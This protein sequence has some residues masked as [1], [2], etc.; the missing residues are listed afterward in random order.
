M[1]ITAW[2]GKWCPHHPN[3]PCYLLRTSEWKHL[4]ASTPQLSFMWPPGHEFHRMP[5]PGRFGF[6]E[7]S[8]LALWNPES[9][10]P[11]AA[12]KWNIQVTRNPFFFLIDCSMCVCVC[13]CVC[14]YQAHSDII[15]VRRMM[16]KL[17]KW[18]RS[19]VG[20]GEVP[21][22]TLWST[23]LNSPSFMKHVS[24]FL[25]WDV[26]K[27]YLSEPSYSLPSIITL[28]K[29]SERIYFNVLLLKLVGVFHGK[30][31]TLWTLIQPQQSSI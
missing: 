13:V 5:G 30:V 15:L 27:V 10:T 16:E 8:D 20:D 6:V 24:C 26:S 21:R 1:Q 17:H 31:E 19:P 3:L 9:L 28:S 14:V 12:S 2:E 7:F 11:F 25:R 4:A 18:W 23:I 29:M 22:W